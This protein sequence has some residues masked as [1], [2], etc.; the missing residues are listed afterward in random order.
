[1]LFALVLFEQLVLILGGFSKFRIVST[2]AHDTDAF[3]EGFTFDSTGTLYEST[4]L[5]GRSALRASQIHHHEAHLQ[6]STPFQKAIFAEGIAVLGNL[7]YVL[8]YQNG[9]AYVFDR[10]DFSYVQTINYPSFLTEGWG[11]TTDGSRFFVSDGN[12]ALRILDQ[13]FALQETIPVSDPKHPDI[14]FQ[15]NELEYVNGDIYANLY[16]TQCV[17][18][19]A[20]VGDRK[21]QIVE[22]ILVDP[23]YQDHTSLRV[24]NGIAFNPVDKKLFVTGKF[25]S[26]FYE[27]DLKTQPV[28]TSQNPNEFCNPTTKDDFQLRQTLFNS[29]LRT[30][31]ELKPSKQ[32]RFRGGGG[33]GDFDSDSAS[34]LQAQAIASL[35]TIFGISNI[36]W[37]EQEDFFH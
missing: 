34:D 12:P 22:W 1:L 37:N 14:R 33:G 2:F 13:N 10:S 26:H 29:M 25:W 36:P 4:G 28:E 31:S 16:Q 5:W 19:I 17:A 30:V 8:T 15:L 35:K 21:G 3:T 23:P 6:R 18:R 20:V 7:I 27:V 9:F 32:L 24:T 11:L